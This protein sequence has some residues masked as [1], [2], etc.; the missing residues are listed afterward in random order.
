MAKYQNCDLV[1]KWQITRLPCSTPASFASPRFT[2]RYL[3]MAFEMM[4]RSINN[5]IKRGLKDILNLSIVFASKM[6]VK[7]KKDK[8]EC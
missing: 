5:I 1:A 8:V 6:K 2:S 7:L 4:A 3:E